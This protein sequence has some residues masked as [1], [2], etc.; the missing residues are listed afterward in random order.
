[1]S[2]CWL[3]FWWEAHET[4]HNHMHRFLGKNISLYENECLLELP[5]GRLMQM[6]ATS[7]ARPSVSIICIWLLITLI[8]NVHRRILDVSPYKKYLSAHWRNYSSYQFIYLEV[9]PNVAI[10]I[11]LNWRDVSSS[12]L[13]HISRQN[14]F[15]A[16][17]TVVHEPAY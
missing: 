12:T 6:C 8:F 3:S 2:L 1:M 14:K 9:L 17:T 16:W 13:S 10:S 15:K 5:F 7:C 4:R 11:Q